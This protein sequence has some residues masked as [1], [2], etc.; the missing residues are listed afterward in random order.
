[1][2]GIGRQAAVKEWGVEAMVLG[3][4]AMVRGEEAIAWGVEAIAW[5]VEAMMRGVDV[6]AGGGGDLLRYLSG[7]LSPYL[8]PRL[9][10]GERGLSYSLGGPRIDILGGLSRGLLDSIR[11]NPLG[12]LALGGDS[13]LS[14]YPP[15]SRS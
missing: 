7:R 14:L 3:V 11:G 15:L 2:V 6:M 9:R 12:D 13:L 8:S 10:S 5:E 4:E 1:M